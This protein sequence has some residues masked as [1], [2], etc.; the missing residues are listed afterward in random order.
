MERQLYSHGQTFETMLAATS[1]AMAPVMA[2]IG[3]VAP[4]RTT[5]LLTGETGT[6]KGLLAR[7]IHASSS[8]SNGPFVAVHCGA[9][10]DT[11]LES[12]LFG[13]E[14]GA[15][16]GA[17]RRKPGK[18]EIANG[19]TLFLDEI[20]TISASAQIKLLDV[21]QERRIQRVGGETGIDVDV[22]LVAATN[23]DLGKLQ[24]EGAFRSDLYYRLNVFPVEVPPLRKRLDDL[25][26]LVERIVRH[27]NALY[28]KDIEGVAPEVLEAFADYSWPGNVRELENV[29]ERAHV[30]ATDRVI[31]CDVIPSEIIAAVDGRSSPIVGPRGTLADVRRA[32]IDTAEQ[33]YLAALLAKH[34]GRIDASAAEAGVTPRQL[35]KLLKRYAIKKERY[36]P[37]PDRTVPI[38]GARPEPP[39][40]IPPKP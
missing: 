2:K 21:L 11:L 17:I 12:E 30:L 36:K 24:K 15:F 33:R 34:R 9:M 28:P 26:G 10:P 7:W 13:H 6:G 22:R 14:K 16:T 19:G 3:A 31:G 37:A 20:G 5:V 40:P 8:R 25:P 4:T 32:A 23:A 1:E 27:H 39:L 38:D 35:H 29:L 18:F